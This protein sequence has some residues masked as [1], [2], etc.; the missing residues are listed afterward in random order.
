M[1]WDASPEKENAYLY[2]KLTFK[3]QRFV[4][5]YDGNA[6]EAAIKAGY[7]KNSAIVIGSENLTKPYIL[8]A[9]QNRTQKK[10]DLVIASREELQDFW[11][12][13][14]KDNKNCLSDRLRA[15]ELLGKSKAVFIEK[16]EVEQK[17]T[18]TVKHEDVSERLNWFHQS[19]N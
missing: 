5:Y 11:T 10:V 16:L 12:S 1:G 18:V 7:S 6:T 17:L 8:A 2:M 9:I 3:Q 13:V 4:D 19:A 14:Y 15:S